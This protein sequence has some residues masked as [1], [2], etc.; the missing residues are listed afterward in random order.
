MPS[1]APQQVVKEQSMACSTIT[2]GT[3]NQK[4]KAK[5]KARNLAVPGPL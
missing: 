5:Q 4:N 1:Q 2:A 3:E